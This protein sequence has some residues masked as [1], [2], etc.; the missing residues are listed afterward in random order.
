GQI[1][2]TA[3]GVPTYNFYNTDSVWGAFWNLTQLWAL[4]WP[5]YYNDFIQTHLAVYKNSG[6][7]SDGLANSKFVSGVGTNFV[8]LVIASAYQAGIKDYDVELAFKA[9]YE[10][11]ARY[12]DR[13][14]GA[15]KMDLK[16]FINQGYISYVPG[17]DTNAE[18]SGFSVSHTL[19]YSFSSYA[20]AQF[21]KSLGKD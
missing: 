14:E 13:N 6:W 7:T 3:N 2:L 15:G 12:K 17:W 1:P 8:G 11:E 5:E 4:V 9:A 21:A 10:N 19:E 18:G 20:V 16:Q